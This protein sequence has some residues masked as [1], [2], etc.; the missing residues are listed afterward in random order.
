MG[1]VGDAGLPAW[2]VDAFRRACGDALDNGEEVFDEAVEADIN[3][4]MG[5]KNGEAG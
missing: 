5:A 1:F 3:P 2:V 4:G